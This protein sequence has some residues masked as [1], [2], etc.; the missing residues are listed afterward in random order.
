MELNRAGF[1][2]KA[3]SSGLHSDAK[4]SVQTI[5]LAAEVAGIELQEIESLASSER[6]L[7]RN[8]DKEKLTKKR[9]L[10]LS[11]LQT[12]REKS[13]VPRPDINLN[14]GAVST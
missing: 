4:D 14:W 10:L 6:I 8:H 11:R 9:K 2:A 1:F 12:N 5:N 7:E 3:R 13:P